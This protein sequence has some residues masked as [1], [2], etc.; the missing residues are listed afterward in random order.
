MLNAG[1]L[2]VTCVLKAEELLTVPAPEGQP[3]V[4]LQIQLPDRTLRADIATKSLRKTQASIRELGA[5]GVACI[6]QGSL[7]GDAITDAGL[8]AQPRAAKVA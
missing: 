3:R 6:L 4:V 1:K 5:N 2:K 7:V 8:S